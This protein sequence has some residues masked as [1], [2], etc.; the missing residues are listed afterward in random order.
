MV[1]TI[2]AL[3]VG[4]VFVFNGDDEPRKRF[5]LVE[6]SVGSALYQPVVDGPVERVAFKTVAG[7]DVDFPVSSSARRRCSLGADVIPV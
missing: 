1:T 6:K 4:D 5:V 3:S 7:E 2:G